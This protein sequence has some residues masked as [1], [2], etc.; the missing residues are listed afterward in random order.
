MFAVDALNAKT[1]SVILLLGIGLPFIV[2]LILTSATSNAL[3][4]KVLVFIG[5][6]SFLITGF[7]FIQL[8]AAKLSL[9][10]GK[11][12]VGGGF[13]KQIVS[14]DDINTPSVTSIDLDRSGIGTRL[15][16]IGMPGFCQGWFKRSNGRRVFALVTSQQAVFIPT[17]LDY[18]VIVSPTDKEGFMEVIK[19]HR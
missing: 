5:A 9:Q 17:K 18:D 3:S 7:L 19:G 1:V 11:L 4:W 10:A 2:P 8:S 15:N 13:Y 14:I 12:S 6:L 16:G